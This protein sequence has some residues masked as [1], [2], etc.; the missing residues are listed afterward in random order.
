MGSQLASISEW[1]PQV[2]LEIESAC[3]FFLEESRQ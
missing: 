2:S 3:K 1:Y